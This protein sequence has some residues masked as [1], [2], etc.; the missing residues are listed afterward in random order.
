MAAPPPGDGGKHLPWL[1]TMRA[2]PGEGS[3]LGGYS[4]G[5]FRV[6]YVQGL[7]MVAD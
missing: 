2:C 1:E 4:D 3:I 5:R 7:S 6:G